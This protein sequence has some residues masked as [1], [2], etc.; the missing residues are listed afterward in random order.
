MYMIITFSPLQKSESPATH[1]YD[2]QRQSSFPFCH[3]IYVFLLSF[4][5]VVSLAIGR[6]HCARSTCS[7]RPSSPN[8][9][10]YTAGTRTR[11]SRAARHHQLQSTPPTLVIETADSSPRFRSCSR[12][13]SRS[14]SPVPFRDDSLLSPPVNTSR[15]R[16]H[17]SSLP[18]RPASAPPARSSFRLEE[19][20]LEGSQ[21][22][23]FSLVERLPEVENLSLHRPHFVRRL[24]FSHSRQYRIYLL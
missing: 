11:D 19:A 22:G 20:E 3:T 14:T 10:L 8:Q 13:R 7:T 23:D 21:E 4:S 18:A 24:L 6:I 5:A 17:R 16:P 1:A 2:S 9:Q 12:S 15:S